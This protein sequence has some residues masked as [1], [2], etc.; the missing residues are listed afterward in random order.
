MN[1]TQLMNLNQNQNL[2]NKEIR[3]LPSGE[4]SRAISLSLISRTATSNYR[5]KENAI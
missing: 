1:P 5:G 3:L 2:K 4:E